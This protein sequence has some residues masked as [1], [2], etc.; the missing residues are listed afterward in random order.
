MPRCYD[1]L[2]RESGLVLGALRSTTRIVLRPA[3]A[4]YFGFSG[5]LRTRFTT[6]RD[7]RKVRAMSA[8]LTP[9][10]YD[11]RIR[12]AVP[13]GIFSIPLSLL[14]RMVADWPSDDTLVGAAATVSFFGPP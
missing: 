8:A 2:E 10:L 9:A 3:I 5:E 14:L 6:D 13:S 4:Y 7:I 1:L 12:F 11:A